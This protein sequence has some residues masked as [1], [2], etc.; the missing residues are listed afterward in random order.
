MGAMTEIGHLLVHTF[1]S[2]VM[3]VFLMRMILQLSKA[4]FYNPISQFIVKYTN[5]VVLPMRRF[6]PSVGPVDTTSLLLAFLVQ[7]LAIIV[8]F[9]MNGVMVP[10]GSLVT[11]ALIGVLSTFVTIY[12]YAV[13]GS[14]IMSW[15]SQGNYHPAAA[16]LMQITEPVMAPFR[17]L[18]P[19]MGG[20]DLSP[21]LVFLAINVLEVMIRHMAISASMPAGIAL[22]IN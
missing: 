6:V 5:P 3:F 20:L 2:L 18:L 12:F 4:D 17:K 8:L 10:V 15:I 14:I 11:W 13:I 9:L 7:V 1:F 16:L 21:I 19:S 22:G